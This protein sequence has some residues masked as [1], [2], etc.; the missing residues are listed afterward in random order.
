MKDTT[1]PIMRKKDAERRTFVGT[2]CWMAPEVMRQE[3]GYSDSADIWSLGICTLE[4]AKA[5][6]PYAKERAMKV[7]VRTIRDPPPNF[8]TYKVRACACVRGSLS[9]QSV[10]R[11]AFSC[12]RVE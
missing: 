6:P 5:Y 9:S 10:G 12:S 8:D 4:L 3:V 2:P 1:D 11:V 7:L